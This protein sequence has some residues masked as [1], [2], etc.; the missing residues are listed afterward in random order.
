[1]YNASLVSFISFQSL[2]AALFW[3]NP[4]PRTYISLVPTSA[5]SGD[6]MGNLI[7]L[8]IELSQS[9]LQKRLAFSEE[10]QCT[11]MEVG[12]RDSSSEIKC[13]VITVELPFCHMD[14]SSTSCLWFKSWYLSN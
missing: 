12:C 14:I 4:D 7:A 11:S 1:M 6:G 3:E 9:M 8:I 5:H 13:S 10:L 2:N